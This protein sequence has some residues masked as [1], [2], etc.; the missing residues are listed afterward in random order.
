MPSIAAIRAQF[1]ALSGTTVFLD[2]AGGSQL[3]QSAIAAATAY[4]RE[5]Y[6][7]LGADYEL[8]RR[9]TATVAAAHEFVETFLNARGHS[10]DSGRVALGSSTTV[11]CHILAN[12]F[13]D[14]SALGGRG[15]PKRII[16]STAGHESNIWPWM[17]LQ[18]RG[19][20]IVPWHPR[21]REDGRWDLNIEGLPAL[22][23]EPTLLVTFPHVSNILG[24]IWDATEVSRLA[25]AAGAQTLV[26]GVAY[27]PH[28]APDV[29]AIGCDWYVYSLYKVFGPHMAAL[30]G[31]HSAFAGLEGP[32]HY[33]IPR[34]EIPYKF[35][36][37]GVSHEG[38]AM[39][40]GG[41]DYLRFLADEPPSEG[42]ITRT[43]IEQAFGVIERQETTLQGRLLTGLA[44]LPGVS[45]WGSPLST[46]ERVPT[47]S[48]T[49]SSRR[50]R[51]IARALN[52]QNLAARYGHFYSKRL[53][54]MI[55]L[56]PDDGVVRVSLV[57][58]NTEAEVDRCLDALAKVI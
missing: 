19:F 7:Q 41:A 39:I 58:Y 4:M 22:L 13:A 31:T 49:V 48:F 21:R 14:A 37:G 47:V 29:A 15:Q 24:D 3:S 11:L 34:S 30:F 43:T 36:L 26:D 57:H 52:A 35:E 44:R 32:N 54:E 45:L 33:F 1:P 53:V 40:V 2:N 38:A 17:R 23:S 12:A 10:H 8:S 16:V 9:A 42:S 55:G 6:V 51:E 28:R 18:S 46:A 5:T 27:A 20:E 50:S 25:H 56:D